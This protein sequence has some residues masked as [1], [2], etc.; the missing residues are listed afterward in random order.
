MRIHL[1]ILGLLIQMPLIFGASI[2]DQKYSKKDVARL[3]EMSLEDLMT[4]PVQTAS[5]KSTTLLETPSTITIID[6]HM[7]EEFAFLNL[8]EAIASISG[9]DV[10]KTIIDHN[11]PTSRG[12]LQNFYGNKVLLLI[13]G[14]PTWQPIYGNGSLDRIHISDVE[15]IEV[16]KGPASVFYGS[17]AFTGAINIIL[18][19]EEI[20]ELDARLGLGTNNAWEG[21]LDA[22]QKIGDWNLYISGHTKEMEWDGLEFPVAAGFELENENTFRFVPKH[23]SASLN[24]SLVRNGHR[25]FVNSFSSVHSFFGIHPSYRGG[26]GKDVDDSGLLFTYQYT[27]QFNER[28]Q[29]DS[30]LSYDD[31]ERFFEVSHDLSTIIRIGGTRHSITSNLDVKVCDSWSLEGGIALENRISNGHDNI[32]GLTGAVL[33]SNLKED[34]DIQENSL[35]LNLKGVWNKVNLVAGVRHTDNQHFGSHT[36]TQLSLVRG[37]SSNQSIKVNYGESFRVPTM[38]ELYFDHPTVV[39]NPQLKPEEA[40]SSELV[41]F[42]AT[43]R[44]YLQAG[45]YFS[46]FDSLIQRIARPEGPPNEYRNLTGFDSHGLEIESRLSLKKVR[47]FCNYNFMNGDQAARDSNFRF[48]PKHNLTAGLSTKW[49]DFGASVSTTMHSKVEGHLETIPS[50][51]RWDLKFSYKPHNSKFEFKH[52]LELHNIGDGDMLTPEYIRQTP[53]INTIPTEFGTMAMYRFSVRILD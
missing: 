34:R 11:I 12:I 17:N 46:R 16:L 47:V 28:I 22:S 50:Q 4:V 48:V 25:F 52:T 44:T 6:R 38:F 43:R 35:F 31:F 49:R 9:M 33:R 45:V 36:S 29:W 20:E 40:Q 7:L 41:Y 39:G 8:A 15:R 18:H 51:Q 27:H 1:A 19:Q 21:G 42:L 23:R 26:G 2:P 5:V 32:D 10:Y 53:N 37:I 30:T 13:N 3:Q 24:A 14:T